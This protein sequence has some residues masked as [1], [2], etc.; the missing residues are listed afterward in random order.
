MKEASADREEEESCDEDRNLYS[1]IRTSQWPP[2]RWSCVGTSHRRDAELP[3]VPWSVPF[4]VVVEGVE[5]KMMV[6]EH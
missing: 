1:Y 2:T 4:V 3:L 5:G 6:G